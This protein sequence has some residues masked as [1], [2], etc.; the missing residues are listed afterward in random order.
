MFH[1][2]DLSIM[3]KTHITKKET[4]HEKDSYGNIDYCK[5]SCR[6]VGNTADIKRVESSDKRLYSPYGRIDALS[7]VRAVECEPK[8]GLF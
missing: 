3:Q 6:N 1:F 5:F 4:K 2:R 7:G 8:G